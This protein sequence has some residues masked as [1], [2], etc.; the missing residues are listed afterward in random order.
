MSAK[1][2]RTFHLP[3]SPGGTSDDKRMSDV[4][5][6]IGAEIVATEK[7]DGSNLTYTRKNVFSRSHAGPPAHP[8]FDLAKATHA[9]IGHMLSEGISVFCEYCYAVHSITYE[10]LPDYSLVFGVRDD[11]AGI[12][13]DWDMVTAQASDLGLPTAPVLF[14][15]VVSSVDELR[16]L[17]DRLSREP[18]TFGGPREGVV[19]RVVSQFPDGAFGRCVAKWV[20]KGH[21]QTDEHWLHQAIVPQRLARSE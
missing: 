14:R 21:V 17:T 13:W 15:G 16:A 11:A 9:R 6:L 4:S 19:V 2:P 7:C 18:S 10:K 12:W 5:A 8:S 3:W 20:R 1:Y